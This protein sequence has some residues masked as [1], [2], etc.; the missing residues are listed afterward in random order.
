MFDKIYYSLGIV[1]TIL[2]VVLFSLIKTVMVFP[3]TDELE[4]KSF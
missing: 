1:Y 4:K 2:S 3:E